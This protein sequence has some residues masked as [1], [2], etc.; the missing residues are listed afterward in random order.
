MWR[1]AVIVSVVSAFLFELEPETIWTL[2]PEKTTVGSP[3]TP[4]DTYAG[5]STAVVPA[6]HEGADP[7]P[8]ET[9]G[10]PAVSARTPGPTSSRPEPGL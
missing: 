5:A 9:T 3:P 7:I 2:T 4:E 10:W 1:V 8:S 6:A